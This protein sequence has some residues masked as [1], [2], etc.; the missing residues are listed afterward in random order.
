MVVDVVVVVG[1]LTG[2]ILVA[3]GVAGAAETAGS[4]ACRWT[5]KGLGYAVASRGQHLNEAQLLWLQVPSAG[6]PPAYFEAP[7]GSLWRHGYGASLARLPHHT[8][9]STVSHIR[10]FGWG[11]TSERGLSSQAGRK[12]DLG[13]SNATGQHEGGGETH[14]CGEG[15]TTSGM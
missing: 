5:V 6:G 7:G 4:G 1:R 2:T 10:I 9:V 15:A 8:T 3:E 11:N 12:K 13:A 14:L